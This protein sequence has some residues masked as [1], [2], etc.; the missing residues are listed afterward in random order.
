MSERALI[1]L[2][3]VAEM[4]GG[5]HPEHAREGSP[6]SAA[7]KP[8]QCGLIQA[9]RFVF[10]VGPLPWLICTFVYAPTTTLPALAAT[11]RGMRASIPGVAT[12][13]RRFETGG[14][15]ARD[16]G[17]KKQHHATSA[18]Q[19]NDHF[20]YPPQKCLDGARMVV[21]DGLAMVVRPGTYGV[22]VTT[23]LP[24]QHLRAQFHSKL[25]LH[26]LRRQ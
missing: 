4:L 16:E 24:D 23:V 8:F 21:I 12:D 7:A 18:P 3:V 6:A 15:A 1:D 26:D 10:S 17:S 5:I 22:M 19:S 2:K 11:T 20:S 9:F 14:H 13:T 25:A